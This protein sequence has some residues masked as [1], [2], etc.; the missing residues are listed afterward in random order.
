MQGLTAC[1]LT[2][3]SF[4]VTNY[5]L[6]TVD[7]FIPCFIDQ[8]FPQTGWNVVKTLEKAGVQVNYNPSQTCC[9]QPAYNSGFWKESG[10]MAVKFINDFPIDRP[11]IVP[12]AS[13]AGFVRNHFVKV[14]EKDFALFFEVE[15]LKRNIVEYTDFLVNKINFT[16]FKAHFPHMVTYHDGCSALREYG[17][18]DEPRILLSKVSGLHL[19]DMEENKTCCGFGGTFMVK[20]DAISTAM[21]EQKVQNAIK[22]GAS[23]IIS[24]EASCLININRYIL[25]NNLP[26]KTMHISD[27]LSKY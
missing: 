6:M 21:V 14:L 4:S 2:N 22:T 13:C 20:F 19:V 18:K 3:Y 7:L 12:S 26:I 5:D 24:T 9:G 16:D 23:Y 25:S 27:V 1:L 15:R 8:M 11:I 17:L 10:K